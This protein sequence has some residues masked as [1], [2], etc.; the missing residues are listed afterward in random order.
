MEL[1]KEIRQSGRAGLGLAG[2][3]RICIGEDGVV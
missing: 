2:V 1:P 3:V